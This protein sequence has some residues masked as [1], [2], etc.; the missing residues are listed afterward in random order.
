MNKQ[1]D[2]RM[3]FSAI[4]TTGLR[5]LWTALSAKRVIRGRFVDARG[6]GCL[7]YWLSECQMTDRASR[8]AW[9][10]SNALFTEA[11]DAAIRRIIVGWDNAQPDAIVKGAGYE[12]EYPAVGY[13]IRRSDVRRAIKKVMRLRRAANTAERAMW[14]KVS[15]RVSAAA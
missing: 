6:N 10:C 13:V 5:S 4:P 1:R 2:L 8:L 11:H 15:H 9:T 14:S 7:F 3:V 12:N